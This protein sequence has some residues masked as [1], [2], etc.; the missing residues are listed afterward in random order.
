MNSSTAQKQKVP[1]LYCGSLESLFFDGK[2]YPTTFTF[3][4]LNWP[5]FTSLF[6]MIAA[7]KEPAT[8]VNENIDFL[9]LHITNEKVFLSN[10]ILLKL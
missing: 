6:L 7:K 10:V 5:I 8:E 1:W 2:H 9:W 3:A 4:G